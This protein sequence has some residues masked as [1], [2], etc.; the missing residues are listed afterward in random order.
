LGVKELSPLHKNIFLL[1]HLKKSIS[2]INTCI[3]IRSKELSK[4]SKHNIEK[5]NNIILKK[6]TRFLEYMKGKEK[7]RLL[8][9]YKEM[10]IVF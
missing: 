8:M 3:Q 4:I 6:N 10:K 1:M 7:I 9:S 5:H 2:Y